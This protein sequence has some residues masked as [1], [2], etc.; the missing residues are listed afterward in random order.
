MILWSILYNIALVYTI[1]Y[2]FY[3]LLFTGDFDTRFFGSC[4]EIARNLPILVPLNLF[5]FKGY[6][7]RDIVA[8]FDHFTQSFSH[9]YLSGVKLTAPDGCRMKLF[10]VYFLLILAHTIHFL[11]DYYQ[12]EDVDSVNGKSS[13]SEVWS[14]V[15]EYAT[16]ILLTMMI[17]IYCTFCWAVDYELKLFFEYINALIS[18]RVVPTYEHLDEFKRCYRKIADDIMFINQIFALYLSVVVVIVG[19]LIYGEAEN[20]AMRIL[21]FVIEAF[22]KDAEATEAKALTMPELR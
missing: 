10:L 11:I 4:I 2:F 20:L 8:S 15:F 12:P 16:A 18:T 5:W 6:H 21:N 22:A 7:I 3:V 14:I 9:V 17:P 1:G 13:A 19:Q